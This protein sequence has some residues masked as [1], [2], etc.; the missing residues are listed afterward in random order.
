LTV[1]GHSEWASESFDFVIN[2]TYAHHNSFCEWFGFPSRNFQFNLQELSI[3][4]LPNNF[5][6]GVTIMDG[7]FPSVIPKGGTPYHLLAHVDKSQLIR[8][9][10]YQSKPLL[11]R[12]S[13]IESN[14]ADILEASIGYLPILKQARYIKS[15]F[16]DRVVDTAALK[17]D[18][19]LT[20]I[21]DH[22]F[23]CF[24]I[25]SAKVITCVST[26]NKLAEII[27]ARL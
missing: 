19:R 10:S 7:S 16:V 6:I 2:A 8:E 5:R 22:G 9:S 1:V 11:E 23:N 21:T 15:L 12:V 25:F 18:A 14:W 24:S 26:A 27:S 13:A 20:D 17:T 4:E 3:I